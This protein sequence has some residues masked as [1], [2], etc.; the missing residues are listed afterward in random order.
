MSDVFSDSEVEEITSQEIPCQNQSKPHSHKQDKGHYSQEKNKVGAAG[1]N[2]NRKTATPTKPIS[3][4]PKQNSFQKEKQQTSFYQNGIGGGVKQPRGE[5]SK[6]SYGAFE[7]QQYRQPEGGP[8]NVRGG[9]S[10]GGYGFHD[11]RPPGF[12]PANFDPRFRDDV[13]FDPYLRDYG[14]HP[15]GSRPRYFGPPHFNRGPQF[16]PQ[17]G[18]PFNGGPFPQGRCPSPAGGPFPFQAGPYYGTPPGFQTGP[19]QGAMRGHGRGGNRNFHGG[20]S[21]D[22]QGN[23]QNFPTNGFK[24][25]N[26]RKVSSSANGDT[27]GN[28]SKVG[29]GPINRSVDSPTFGANSGSGASLDSLDDFSP[30]Q[31]SSSKLKSKTQTVNGGKGMPSEAGR[32]VGLEGLVGLDELGVPKGLLGDRVKN[33]YS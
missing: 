21:S 14:Y 13:P 25:D 2:Q 11:I 22:S 1:V 16:R 23:R 24:P 27:G 17:F 32:D 18:P 30:S 8:F 28:N 5:Y 19:P 7:Q 6:Q 4:K 31:D 15:P 12:V 26:I 33:Y 20:I 10:R 29:S 9:Y 3:T